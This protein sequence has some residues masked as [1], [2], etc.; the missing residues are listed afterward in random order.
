MFKLKFEPVLLTRQKK[1]RNW[2]RI[3]NLLCAKR[4]LVARN[5]VLFA[6]LQML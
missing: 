3:Q 5:V 6:D 4:L 2:I 1:K